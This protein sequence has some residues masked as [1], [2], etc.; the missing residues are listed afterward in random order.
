MRLDSQA[1]PLTSQPRPTHD[2]QNRALF[3]GV[4][5]LQRAQD[6]QDRRA[7]EPRHLEAIAN[8][9]ESIINSFLASSDGWLGDSAS[10]ED[11]AAAAASTIVP[12][13]GDNGS[14]LGVVRMQKLPWPGARQ[15]CLSVVG[16]VRWAV[17]SARS[18]SIDSRTT[19]PNKKGMDVSI[20]EVPAKRTT[21]N[22]FI[23]GA[24]DSCS[25]CNVSPG[26]CW[27]GLL[28]SPNGVTCLWMHPY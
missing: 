7:F 4:P 13:V 23:A 22:V 26:A 3:T 11:A 19:T 17:R 2:P 5:L 21:D 1:S 18:Q 15:S 28:P 24:L 25:I 9:A 14:G 6:D 8:T 10:A 16:W 20:P 27:V 12:P